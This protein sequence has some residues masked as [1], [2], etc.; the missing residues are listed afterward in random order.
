MIRAVFSVRR[1]GNVMASS[2]RPFQ[3]QT[4]SRLMAGYRQLTQGAERLLRQG[5]TALLWGVQVVAFPLYVALQSVRSAARTLEATKPWQQVMT[6]LTGEKPQLPQLT[7]DAPIRALL[8]ITQPLVVCQSGSLRQVDRHGELLRQSRAESVMVNGQW[9]LVPLQT[10]VCGVASDLASRQLV[11]VTTNNLIFHG[12]TDLQREQLHRAITLL[13]AEY[14]GWCRRQWHQK[15]LQSPGL[16]LPQA[17]ANQWLPVRWLNRSLAWMQA[18]PL[19]QVTNLFG[20]A[21]AVLQLDPQL[22]DGGAVSWWDRALSGPWRPALAGTS[23]AMADHGAALVANPH[24]SIPVPY[25]VS[26]WE[27]LVGVTSV[28][29]TSPESGVLV[30]AGAS[31]VAPQPRRTR[32]VVTYRTEDGTIVFA[33]DAAESADLDHGGAWDDTHPNDA[34]ARPPGWGRTM[35]GRVDRQGLPGNDA[36][37]TQAALVNYV[38]H[39]LVMVLR[40]LDALLHGAETWLQGVWQ[41]L[42]SQL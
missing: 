15:H 28:P 7:A 33:A 8:S 30:V 17:E 13:M 23:E 21:E 40:W 4:I 36:I 38:D 2:S 32:E 14:A 25:G 27:S 9:Q 12:L 10:P 19:A 6:L 16:P 20:E 34:T 22:G 11:L 3:S 24:T 39:P 37:E 41:W 1:V 31:S 5:Q 29:D 18:S 42:R 35:G 26:V